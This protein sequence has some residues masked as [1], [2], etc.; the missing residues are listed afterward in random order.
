MDNKFTDVNITPE[1]VITQKTQ[2]TTRP[3]QTTFDVKNYLQAKLGKDESQKTLVIRLLPFS[4]EGGTPFQK[5]YMHQVRV[6]KAVSESGWKTLVCP[7]HNKFGDECPFCATAQKARELKQNATTEAEKKKYNDIEFL[8]RAKEMWIVRCIERGHESD[9]V[10]FW[11]FSHSKKNDG[12][13]DK[14]YNIF[15]K[16]LNAPKPCNIFDLNDGK[17][18]EITLERNSLNKTVIN[19][20]DSG[21]RT[22]LSENYDE[23]LAWINNPKKWNEV[24]TVKPYDYMSILVEGGVPI[25]N[26]E[27]KV[28]MDKEEI[29]IEMEAKQEKMAQE[30][31]MRYSKDYSAEPENING[32]DTEKIAEMI[33]D[34]PF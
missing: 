30:S 26:R 23:A 8:N 20:I 9:G 12:V 21:E 11:L 34:L 33:D 7:I 29:R 19:V 6:D 32:V 25:Y 22:P 15:Q 24:Y 17:D 31:F 5:V 4:P 18:L 10:K 2:E 16:R 28:Y 27:K 1:V 14:I 3:T 13:F